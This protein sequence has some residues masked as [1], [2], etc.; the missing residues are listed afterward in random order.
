MQPA[1]SRRPE[2]AGCAST[3][4]KDAYMGRFIFLA[5]ALLASFCVRAGNRVVEVIRFDVDGDGKPDRIVLSDV[6][7]KYADDSNKMEGNYT[8]IDL[9]LTGSKHHALSNPDRWIRFDTNAE[10]RSRINGSASNL[11]ASGRLILV[12]TVEGDRL[13]L[14]IGHGYASDPALLSVYR[15]SKTGV[16]KVM[17]EETDLVKVADIDHDGR[18]DIVGRQVSEGMGPNCSS[19]NPNLVYTLGD[20]FRI[21]HPLTERYDRKADGFFAADNSKYLVLVRKDGKRVLLPN[22]QQ[23]RCDPVL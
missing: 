14:A 1:I 16:Q 15:I 8:R 10:D 5:C 2:P 4:S 23:S 13:L 7:D 9:F 20:R 3:V 22:D 12:D 21:N 17:S 6:N 18:T 19:Y 11:I